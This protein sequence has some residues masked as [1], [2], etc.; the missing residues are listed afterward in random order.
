V[1]RPGSRIAA[2][3]IALGAVAAHVFA[4]I[5]LA[6]TLGALLVGMLI[7]DRGV[8]PAVRRLFVTAAAIGLACLPYIAWRARQAYGPVNPIHTET[9]GL[10]SLRDGVR[11]V[12][13]GV[14]WDWLGDLWLL[15]PLAWIPLWRSGRRNPAALF[16]LTSSLAVAL[17]IFDP[18]V[19]AALEPRIGYLLMRL[20]WL[21][22]V[23]VLLAWWLP[24]LVERVRHDR[25]RPRFLAA[26]ALG[27]TAVLLS[28][29]VKDGASVVLHPDRVR[30]AERIE[31]I[32]RWRAALT[33]FDRALPPG[34]VVLAD[35]ATSYAIP[36]FTRSYVVTLADQHSSPNDSLAL[37]RIL[38]A[39]DALD[40][41]GTWERTREVIARH[42]V[43]LVMIN[44]NFLDT[45]PFDY[46]APSREWAARARARFEREPAAFE[47][48]FRD[49][50]ITV[51]QVHGGALAALRGGVPH[52]QVQAY[53]PAHAPIARRLGPGLP[54]LQDLRLLPRLAAPGD[55][56]VGV[57]EWRVLEP[58]AAG[59]YRV[60][61]R[62]DRS[63]PAGFEPPHA[64]DKPLRKL[65]E[66]LR[67]ERYRFRSDHL[68]TNGAYGVD[69]WSPGE[70]VRDTFVVGVPADAAPGDYR[71]RVQM[72]RS[73]HY[74]NL[75]LSDYFSDEDQYSGV[76]MGV[77]RVQKP[78]VPIPADGY[79]HDAG[80]H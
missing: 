65:V 28:I 29:A 75:R 74:P 8:G 45:P 16:V 72:V 6:V 58:L 49:D 32:G 17:M 73:P 43:S 12:M 31:D 60:M 35:P 13:P 2:V 19:V 78:G 38:D 42:G 56:V 46:W 68:P 10:L 9:Q 22:P 7:R 30:A 57:A 14:L 21:V 48:V 15:F 52:P 70:M 62:F 79:L 54:V 51:F 40:P 44:E 5:H 20:V 59:S 69:L 41:Y 27:F 24:E 66:H 77:F 76:A 80:S 67:G 61:V 64:V 26:A 63:L 39:R 25:G 55:T 71:V 47:S 33:R 36:A 50:G 4:A 11:V 1:R 34:Q 3:L 23:S 37:R 53:D 18:P